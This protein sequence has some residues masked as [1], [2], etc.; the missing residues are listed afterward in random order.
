[1]GRVWRVWSM[2]TG[3]ADCSQHELV[4]IIHGLQDGRSGLLGHTR[5][6]QGI[7]LTAPTIVWWHKCH[8]GSLHTT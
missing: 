4:A 3:L 8:R 7:G 2:T 1:M 6:P 5:Q